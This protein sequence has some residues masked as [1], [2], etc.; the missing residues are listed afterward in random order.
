MENGIYTDIFCVDTKTTNKGKTEPKGINEY[1]TH[2]S[3]Q[4]PAMKPPSNNK[5]M[6]CALRSS[7][8]NK[9]IN[10]HNIQS[11]STFQLVC[12]LL[13]FIRCICMCV[14]SPPRDCVHFCI[15]IYR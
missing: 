15:I 6:K 7:C 1:N 8:V 14:P 13:L 5:Y 4:I 2:M 10:K 12:F 11:S 9:Q 3:V